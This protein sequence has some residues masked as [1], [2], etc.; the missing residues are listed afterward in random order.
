MEPAE[1][2]V[3]REHTSLSVLP[4]FLQEWKWLISG[5]NDVFKAVW[6]NRV[7]EVLHKMRPGLIVVAR[8]RVVKVGFG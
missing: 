5:R 2:V 6:A 4:P 7:I 1:F 3:G 8:S